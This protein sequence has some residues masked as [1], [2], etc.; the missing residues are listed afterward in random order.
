VPWWSTAPT[1]ARP[2]A[3]PWAGPCT[4]A[5]RLEPGTRVPIGWVAVGDPAQ[6]HSPD[7]LDAIR[8][9]LDEQGG[10][11]PFVF[12]TDPALARPEAMRAALARYTTALA[13]HHTD[14]IVD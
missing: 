4:S 5:A 1:W 12:G 6:L 3:S 13:A 9:A 8:A 7:D 11:L 2:A 10:F 14:R